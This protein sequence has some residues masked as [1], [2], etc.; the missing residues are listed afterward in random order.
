MLKMTD[1]DLVPIEALSEDNFVSWKFKMQL[2][3]EK[4]DIKDVV[5][6]TIQEP[7]DTN[8]ETWRQWKKKESDAKYYISATLDDRLIKHVLICKML[9][10][11][12]KH[13]VVCSKKNLRRES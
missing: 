2:L 5:D 11:C 13:F 9:K 10:K 8:S 3:F 4:R 7:E 1:K 6:G 12:G